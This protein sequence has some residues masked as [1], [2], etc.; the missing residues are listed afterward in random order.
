MVFFSPNFRKG[1]D[2]CAAA[3][4]RH[5]ANQTNQEPTVTAGT[6]VTNEEADDQYTELD[7]A[8]FAGYLNPI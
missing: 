8:N 3:E 6:S 2:P 1:I 5:D 7:D 4:P